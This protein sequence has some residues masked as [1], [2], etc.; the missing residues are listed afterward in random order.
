MIFTK[1][2]FNIQNFNNALVHAVG[3][4]L[5]NELYIDALKSALIYLTERI[6]EITGDHNLDG[7]S[8][9]TKAF[10]LNNPI[11]KINNL[12]TE[13]EKNEQKGIMQMLQGVYSAFRNPLNH[14]NVAMTEEECIKKLIIIDTLLTYVNTQIRIDNINILVLFDKLSKNSLPYYLNR[15]IDQQVNNILKFNHL[16]L[17]GESGVGKTNLA[18][19]Y[20]LSNNRKFYHSISFGSV[21]NI[22][23][24]FRLFTEELIDKLEE[25]EKI[26]DLKN[27]DYIKNIKQILSFLSQNFESVTI[28]LDEIFELTETDFHSLFNFILD[29]FKKIDSNFSN[30]NIII[31]SIICPL[32]YLNTLTRQS[33]IEKIKE[34]VSFKEMIL[35]TDNEL[36]DLFNLI[37]NILN[38]QINLSQE[39]LNIEYKPRNLKR[40]LKDAYIG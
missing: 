34:I 31:T 12:I 11:I 25:S 10:S 18:I 8:L 32:Q 30:I 28:H 20:M 35:W 6:R 24:L 9:V 7:D 22:D 40:I 27:G 37:N 21:N 15:N 38:T 19:K 14:S 23:E 1:K 29:T 33:D 2:N 13:S 4:R 36:L 5:E 16:W 3:S 39:L 26:L 17:Y